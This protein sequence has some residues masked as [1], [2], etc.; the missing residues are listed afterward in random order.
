MPLAGGLSGSYH[1][2]LSL[3]RVNAVQ[4][5]QARPKEEDNVLCREAR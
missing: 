2:K 4:W 5:G 1:G 3:H